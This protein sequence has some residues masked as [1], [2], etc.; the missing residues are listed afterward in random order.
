MSAPEHRPGSPEAVARLYLLARVEPQRRGHPGP[1]GRYYQA[2][3]QCP[4]HGREVAKRALE[5]GEV[6]DENDEEVEPTRH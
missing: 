3:L 1:R 6:D 2:E 4:V 5:S